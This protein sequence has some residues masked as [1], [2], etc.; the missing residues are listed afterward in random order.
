MGI[1]DLLSDRDS[2]ASQQIRRMARRLVRHPAFGESD[3][4]DI[5]QDLAMELF[6]KYR[7]FD[8]ARAQ[9]STFI[10]RVLKHKG[11]SIIRA[12]VAEK[13]HFRRNGSSLNDQVRD[14]DGR[15]VER[16]QTIPEA[17]SKRHTGQARRERSELKQLQLD[18]NKILEA[19]PEGLKQLAELL[20]EMSKSAA[21]HQ[22][23]KS[24]RQ[25]ANDVARLRALFEDADLNVYG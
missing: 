16:A 1:D 4:P 9:E 19:S 8:P 18:V 13:R 14:S 6:V 10:A 20:T 3:R 12:R 25:V 21:S 2:F 11:I 7:R 23:G 24:R 17:A 5:E 15:S 22:L